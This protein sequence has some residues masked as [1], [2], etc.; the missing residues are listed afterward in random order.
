[1][2]KGAE[3]TADLATG[4]ERYFA[5]APFIFGYWSPYKRFIKLLDRGKV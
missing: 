1:L 4:I 3:L 2:N 5:K